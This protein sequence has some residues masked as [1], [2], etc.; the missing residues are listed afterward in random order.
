ML[1]HGFN[2]M[3]AKNSTKYL[4]FYSVFLWLKIFE[5]KIVGSTHFLKLLC[6][7]IIIII[8]EI[9]IERRKKITNKNDFDKI[10]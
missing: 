3:S 1:K 9:G 8:F 2:F 4:R 7:N 6:P 10:P 5:I